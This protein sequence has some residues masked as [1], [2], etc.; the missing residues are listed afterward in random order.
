MEE[1]AGMAEQDRIARLAKQIDSLSKKD[2]HLLLTEDQVVCLRRQGAGELHAI[3]LDFVSSLNR[4]VSPAVLELTPTEYAPEMFR[5]SGANLIQINTQ[6]RIIQIAFQSPAELFSTE[7]FWIPYMLAG[8]VTSYNQE[9]LER[10][11]VRSKALFYCIE[12]DKTSW[13]YFEFLNGRTG[14]FDRNQLVDLL[15]RLV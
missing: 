6:G 13:H 15:E 14:I 2:Q 4:L 1:Q 3:C 8:E 12:Q 7:K 9:M 10:T 11:Q 5:L